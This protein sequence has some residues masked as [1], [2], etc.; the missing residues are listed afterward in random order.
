[1]ESTTVPEA[2]TWVMMVLGFIGLGYA[3]GRPSRSI[4]VSRG[5]FDDDDDWYELLPAKHP[6]REA[7]T[8]RFAVVS[9]VMMI[10]GWGLWT[11]AWRALGVWE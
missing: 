9:L 7:F 4:G 10:I 8:F 3:E 11:L 2:S 1:M 6:V 5:L